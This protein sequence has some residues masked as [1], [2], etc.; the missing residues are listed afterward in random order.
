MSK[1]PNDYGDWLDAFELSDDDLEILKKSK[2]LEDIEEEN[3]DE[4]GY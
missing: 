2:T 4:S 1:E 3:E